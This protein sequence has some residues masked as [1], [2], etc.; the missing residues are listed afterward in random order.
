MPDGAAST[1]DKVSSVMRSLSTE[2]T[3]FGAIN[4]FVFGS[5]ARG[6]RRPD[7]DL[8][9]FG[10]HEPT[11]QFSAF[12]LLKIQHLIEDATALEVH[13]PT[14]DSCKVERDA[15]GTLGRCPAVCPTHA[16]T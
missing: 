1:T 2:I 15:V 3:R 4:V 5:F 6:D 12:D 8:D 13:V 16:V 11:G 10:D 14:H 9:T 7:S